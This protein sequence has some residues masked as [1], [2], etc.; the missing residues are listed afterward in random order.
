MRHR[1]TRIEGSRS[2]PGP[3]SGL[4]AEVRVRAEV[5]ARRPR[6]G[7]GSGPGSW[8]RA[9]R[10]ARVAGR[11]EGRRQEP[12]GSGVVAGAGGSGPVVVGRRSG[13]VGGAPRGLGGDQVE[14]RQ[15]VRELLL[16][17]NRR[18]VERGPD[19]R[20][21]G[22]TPRS[23][24]TSR[25]WPR[26]WGSGFRR[27][28]RRHLASEALTES[29]QGVIARAAVHSTRPTSIELMADDPRTP[30]C[31]CST[32]SPIPETWELDPP[33]SR[34]RRGHRCG[35]RSPPVGPRH[36]DGDQGRCRC[37]RARAPGPGRPVSRRRWLDLEMTQGS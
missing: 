23:W 34:V 13:V 24:P 9:G 35:P 17:G 21:P 28:S 10:T 11:D 3:K 37:G 7:S 36:P 31:W 20:R 16:A 26:S 8:L 29:H 2:G 14:G 1:R 27:V 12:T 33:H 32:G 30:S 4:R 22:R 19:D 15:A 5:R 6:S 25:S 18:R